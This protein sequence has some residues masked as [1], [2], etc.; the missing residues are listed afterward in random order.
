V[1]A[2]GVELCLSFLLGASVGYALRAAISNVRRA[3]VQQ[4][5]QEELARLY[6][7]EQSAQVV[8]E[9]QSSPKP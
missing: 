3:K 9:E 1:E 4:R 2:E 7:R 5:R 8:P 6:A